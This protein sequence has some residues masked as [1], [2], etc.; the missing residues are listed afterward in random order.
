MSDTGRIRV[1]CVDDHPMILE[2]IAA[3]IGKQTDMEIS[4]LATSGEQAVVL[5]QQYRPDVTLM[6]LL[7]PGLGG[8]EAITAIRREY[9][10]AKIV[11]LTMFQGEE[12][13]HRALRAG[14][15]TYLLKGIRADELL[16]TIRQVH[17]GERLLPA[18]VASL[19]AAR[20]SQALLTRREVDVLKLVARGLRNKEIAA[21]LC[22][23]IETTK[24][25]VKSILAK[26]RVNDRTAAVQVA[27][28]RGVIHLSR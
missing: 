14:A 20:E 13:I 23:S 9:P 28:Q 24:T 7:M 18:P 25:H 19:L 27:Q 2:G 3:I 16:R 17:A 11:V 6:D 8:L 21:D 10:E 5:F 12:D 15:A 1:M 22:I 26:L 4:A